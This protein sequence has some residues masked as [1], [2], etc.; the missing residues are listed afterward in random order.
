MRLNVP[1]FKGIR[2]RFAA[3]KL[4]NVEAQTAQNCKLGN[5]NLRP[6]DNYLY[7][8]LLT[9]KGIIKAVYLYED[10]YWFEWEAEVDLIEAP[11]SG[12]TGGKFFYT[13][14]G[15]PK[16]SDRTEA[17]AGTGAMPLNYYPLALP[18]PLAKLSGSVGGPPNGTG[19][20]RYVNYIWTIV[21]SWGEESYPSPASDTFT[22]KNGERVALS[23][24]T[25][26]WQASTAYTTANSVY[27]VGD[28]GGTYLYKCVTAGTTGGSEPTWNQTVG[29]YTLDGTVVWQ[30]FENNI[31]YKRIYRLAT[32]DEYG[33]YQ[34]VDQI[35]ISATTYNDDK[36]DSELSNS[37]TTISIDSGGAGDADH[38]PPP[39]GLQGLCYLGNGIALGFSGKDLYA[40]V[41]Y[42]MWAF[43]TAYSQALPESIRS[44][45]VIGEGVAIISTDQQIYMAQGTTPGSIT[46]DPLPNRKPNLSKRGAVAWKN[47]AVYPASDGLRYVSPGANTLL[48]EEFYTYEEWK[49]LY[50]STMHGVVH[51]NK[52]FGFY[53]SDSE[54]GIVID[55]VNG[56]VDT[57]DFYCF[58]TYVDPESDTLYFIRSTQMSQFKEFLQNPDARST[59]GKATQ[60]DLTGGA[61]AMAGISQ[62][63]YPRNLVITITDGDGSLSALQITVTGTKADGS[64]GTETFTTTTAGS[65]DLN[66]AWAQIDSI[67]IDSVAGAGAGDAIDIGFGKKFGLGNAVS[68]ESDLLKVLLND[69][70]DAV[71]DQT[72]STTYNT[73]QFGTDPD[74]ANDYMVM[75]Q[76]D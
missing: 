34:Y 1:Y 53:S 49:A 27:E 19:D 71:G 54:G 58:A 26:V 30:C 12:D 75:Y 45:T 11:V 3:D 17:T 72:I 35:A 70:D 14:D 61:G 7:D 4:P 76:T 8:Q 57:L 6:W 62:P 9:N 24:M 55:L 33:T 39:D 41:P 63:D 67:T 18:S 22:A 31:S 56:I 44:V 59:T 69:D 15:I 64:S 38:D 29:G 52:Y 60:Y 2:P 5:G 36:T 47:G 32:G 65:H 51:D 66:E 74:A 13:G 73:I 28:E 50:P 43:P 25:M 16:K 10:D 21:S 68:A 42:K 40:S 23:A 20:D 48:T 37:C 46:I